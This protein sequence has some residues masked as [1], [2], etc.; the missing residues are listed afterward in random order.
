M[1]TFRLFLAVQANPKHVLASFDVSNAFLN[2]ELSE[3]VII[4]TQ[5]A[6]ELIQFGLVKPGTLYQCTKACY[7]LREAPKLW[8]EARDKTLTSFVFQIDHMEY[9]L[10]QSTYHP[11]LW[12]VVRAPCQ[13]MSKKVRLPDDSDLPDISVFGEHEHVAAFL[14][15]VDDFL[16]AG[17]REI[18]QPLLARLLDVWKGSN[19]DYLGRQP[20]DVDTMRFL[21]LD[22]E[23]GRRRNMA[24]TSTELHLCLPSRDV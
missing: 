22:I 16:A 9:S 14:V 4:L 15:Y 8:E 11:S 2:A 24:R 6:P 18:L 23:L 17:P 3:D 19:P 5:P 20:G 7:G 1:H 21:G 13:T 10:R 12:F